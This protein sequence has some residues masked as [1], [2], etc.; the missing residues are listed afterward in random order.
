MKLP[1]RHA[2]AQK[3]HGVCLSPVLAVLPNLATHFLGQL[4]QARIVDVMTVAEKDLVLNGNQL[5]LKFVK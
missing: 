1:F 4:H 3:H 2:V 5:D